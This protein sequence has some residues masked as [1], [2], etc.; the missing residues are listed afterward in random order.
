MLK[1]EHRPAA[2]ANLTKRWRHM[3][4]SRVR[5]SS[6]QRIFKSHA[7]VA[8]NLTSRWVFALTL[9][10]NLAVFQLAN[11]DEVLSDVSGG[12]A[13]KADKKEPNASVNL[14]L[15]EGSPHWS[16]SLDTGEQDS[17]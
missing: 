15:Q 16:N 11:G 9:F 5:S 17:E 8:T 4:S 12:S 10:C 14:S 6:M 2:I 13:E 1:Q 3:H 7:S